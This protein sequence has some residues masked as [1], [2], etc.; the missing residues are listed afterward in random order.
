M[1][2][3]ILLPIKYIKI[4]IFIS[5]LQ[6][7]IINFKNIIVFKIFSARIFIY[8]INTI[9]VIRKKKSWICIIIL[10]LLFIFFINKYN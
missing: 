10:K 8:K 9:T 5:N 2:E 1:K 6:I 7:K 4:I 3:L